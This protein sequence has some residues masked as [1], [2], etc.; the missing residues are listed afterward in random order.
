MRI[1]H[2]LAAGLGLALLHSASAVAA[3][4]KVRPR[5][6]AS[7]PAPDV[8]RETDAQSQDRAGV[9]AR[10][11]RQPIHQ[12]IV[13]QRAARA[14]AKS[15]KRVPDT[16]TLTAHVRE[17]KDLAI[18]GNEVGRLRGELS[19]IT[20]TL[21][22]AMPLEG[23]L[24][25]QPQSPGVAEPKE[26]T[27]KL[28]D[29]RNSRPI[30]PQLP[31]NP[32]TAHLPP[33]MDERSGDRSP[34]NTAVAEAIAYLTTTATPGSTMVRQGA[35]LAIGRLHPAFSVKLA[36]AIKR[37]REAGLNAAGV[38]SA[39]RPPAFGVGGFSDKFDS[40]HS[41]GLAAD[42][43]GI[44]NPG[45]PSAH[46]W[47]SIVE[48][49]GLYLVYGANDRAEFNH[50]QFIPDKVAPADLRETITPAAPK[51]LREMW[52][53]SG[54]GDA[55]NFVTAESAAKLA[56][57]PNY[58]DR[59]PPAQA[60]SNAV[61]AAGPRR[62][63]EARHSAAAPASKLSKASREPEGSKG[64]KPSKLSKLSKHPGGHGITARTRVS[65]GQ[66]H[67]AARHKAG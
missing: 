12:H 27:L 38:F 24:T 16:A 1:S 28:P 22:G 34:A 29:L 42:I 32:A 57:A 9:Q 67:A 45:S 4:Q 2:C 10:A 8:L 25:L 60:A 33:F 19:E 50:T 20:R 41:Y 15:V 64:S 56:S 63:L 54:I 39:Y 6:V 55:V 43:T 31:V 51:D 65:A 66:P 23:P 5:L 11:N 14:V 30:N 44:G 48:E 26:V 52:L 62:K 3:P 46:L 35:A 17:R 59:T 61:T 21:W 49:V 18:R 53:A 36:E 37:A 58:G 47:Q 13:R 7:E 40:L